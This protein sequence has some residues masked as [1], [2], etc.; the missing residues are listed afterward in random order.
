MEISTGTLSL[1]KS[2]AKCLAA[3]ASHDDARPHLGGVVVELELLRAW[4]TDGVRVVHARSLGGTYMGRA[5]AVSV[6]VK[7]WEQALKACGAADT[8][9]VVVAQHQGTDGATVLT[10]GDSHV[11]IEIVA[12]DGSILSSCWCKA[13]DGHLPPVD[14]VLPQDRDGTAPATPAFAVNQALLRDVGLVAKAAATP[15]VAVYP[16]PGPDD[17]LLA[18]VNGPGDPETEWTMLIMPSTKAVAAT[19]TPDGVARWAESQSDDVKACLGRHAAEAEPL[20]LT[21]PKAAPKKR[22]TRRGK[23]GQ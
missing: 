17:A 18:K 2:E 21:A 3:C 19:V 16:G 6:P 12:D 5:P 22:R 13:I 8:F 23:G 9:R 14:Q 20:A 1:T 4:A 15:F 7:T 11:G 10:P